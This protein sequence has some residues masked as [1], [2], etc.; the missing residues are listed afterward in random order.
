MLWR[1]RKLFQSKADANGRYRGENGSYNVTTN[2]I[3]LDVNAGANSASELSRVTLLRTMSHELTHALQQNSPA[4]YDALKRA[5]LDVLTSKS[6]ASIEEMAA[7]KMEQD[8]S[9]KDDGAALDEV[10]AEACEN[11]LRDSDAMEQ[12]IAQHPAEAKT[13]LEKVKQFFTDIVNAIRAAFGGS[14]T[15]RSRE[16]TALMQQAEEYLDICEKWS[17]A[18]QDT[19][20]ISGRMDRQTGDG[21]A[22]YQA[23]VGYTEDGL[24]VYT[25]NFPE[26]STR[27][28]RQARILQLVQDVW[29]KTPIKLQI[30][31]NG[32]IET[33]TARF[34]PYVDPNGNINSDATKLAYG[35]RKGTM[36]DQKVTEK[37]AD[38]FPEIISNSTYDHSTAESGK[39]TYSHRGVTVWHYFANR[40]GFINER[41]NYAEY[42]VYVDVKEKSEGDYV[43]S[44]AAIKQK[45][46]ER[47]KAP[48]LYSDPKTINASVNGLKPA[49]ANTSIAPSDGSVKFSLRENVEQTKDL[50]AVHNLTEEKLLKAMKLGGFPMPSIAVTKSSIGHNTFGDISLVFGRETIDP[51]ASRKNKVYSAD[52]WTP[53]FP[54]IEYEADTKAVRR[55]DARIRELTNK[56]PAD[57]QGYMYQYGDL[58]DMLNRYG[59]KDGIVD[60]ALSDS[61]MR[62]AYVADMGGDVT[63]EKKN[64]TVSGVSD[65]MG[66]KYMRTLALFNYDV[67]EMMHMPLAQLKDVPGLGEIWSEQ[68]TRDAMRL[69]KVISKAAAYMRGELGT[70]TVESNDVSA[71]NAK[72]DGQIDEAKYKAW[73]EDLFNGVEGKSGVYNHKKRYAPSG[74]L[75]SF[76]A[77]HYPVSVENIALAMSKENGGDSK[78]VS[79]FHG[80]KTLRAATAETFRSV[81]EMHKK[82]NRLQALTQEQI[83]AQSSALNKRLY[84]VID[85]VLDGSNITGNRFMD[86]DIVGETLTEIAEKPY[87]AATIRS[88]FGQYQFNVS[89][90][91]A[92]KIKK[93]LDDIAQMPVNMFEAKPQ[94]AVYFDEVK[95]AVVPDSLNPEVL[96]RLEALVPDVRTY[97]DGDEAQRL[98]LLNQRQDLRFQMRDEDGDAQGLVGVFDEVPQLE[99]AHID[100]RTWDNMSDRRVHSFMNDYPASRMWLARMASVLQSDVTA[101]TA[102]QRF[103]NEE[104]TFMG[105]KRDTTPLLAEMKDSGYTWQ[106]MAD[107]FGKMAEVFENG[108]LE[109]KVPETAIWKRAELILDRAVTEGYTDM[110]GIEYRPDAGYM[111]YKD[112]LPGAKAREIPANAVEDTFED[113]DNRLSGGETAAVQTGD[114]ERVQLQGDTAYQEKQ[115]SAKSG[116]LLMDGEPSNRKLLSEALESA[117]QTPEELRYVQ[118]YKKQAQKITEMEGLLV[119]RRAEVQQLQNTKKRTAD[120]EI[121]MK[122]L[123]TS[124]AETESMIDKRD[125]GLLKMEAMEPLRNVLD[126]ERAKY[127]ETLKQAKKDAAARQQEKDAAKLDN[128]L[129]A[130]QMYEGRKWTAKLRNAEDRVAKANWKL[131]EMQAQSLADRMHEGRN[132]QMKN[133]LKPLRF[134]G[135]WYT[136]RESIRTLVS[137]LLSALLS[138]SGISTPV[139]LS[140]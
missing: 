136:P 36:S 115:R 110:N 11:M 96:S 66:D 132:G 43:Y 23:R 32:H 91:T 102:G 22:Q 81:D 59:G 38:D 55:I 49:I 76:D 114:G 70:K 42:N 41:Q 45:G 92:G 128:A 67:D 82:S 87:S 116:V 50:V 9:L 88:T 90:E 47:T 54:R 28:Q 118:N 101:S 94:R 125:K 40:I 30:M 60:K 4:Q 26:G 120:Q 21:D 83:D 61:S 15:S 8:S 117:A 104:G 139:S 14:D 106:Q 35:N 69:S 53:T 73:L 75:R 140:S 109:G 113:V 126:R 123:Q 48:N 16:A 80:A 127:R 84:A 124:I 10:V 71:T 85:E 63:M 72:I 74:N 19:A 33:I 129:L 99:E 95:Y 122:N 68:T 105:Q 103:M 34:D 29:S 1:M 25:S 2:T 137:S 52:A 131:E 64:V 31:R 58:T 134:Q 78:N 6:G 44:F 24:P 56:I 108:D 89:E 135:V 107:V 121:R 12:L 130:T 86:S 93:L 7:R 111:R 138:S 5:V 46:S 3:R 17:K 133:S 39:E 100:Q 18:L 79:G 98:E 97:A 27:A 37:L 112:E 20:E 13:F 57:Y 51:K 119:E 65:A 77:L 62:A